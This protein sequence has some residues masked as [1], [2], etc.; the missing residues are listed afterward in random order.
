MQLI[1]QELENGAGGIASPS[2]PLT[3][4]LHVSQYLFDKSAP[5]AIEIL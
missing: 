5:N 1:I 2:K 4:K 3:D